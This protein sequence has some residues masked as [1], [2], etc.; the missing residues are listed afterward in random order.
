MSGEFDIGPPC[1]GRL[2]IVPLP[3]VG[4]DTFVAP[5]VVFAGSLVCAVV[6]D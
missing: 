6:L 1:L 4:L 5:V 2:Q 3:F